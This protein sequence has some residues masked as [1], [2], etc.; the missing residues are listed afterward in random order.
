MDIASS[1]MAAALGFSIL[2]SPATAEDDNNSE[3]NT[4]PVPSNI[5]CVYSIFEDGTYTEEEISASPVLSWLYKGY[6][7][8]LPEPEVLSEDEIREWSFSECAEYVGLS[9]DDF[10]LFTQTVNAE[11]GNTMAD[12][13]Y[14]AA[15]IWNRM[16]CKKWYG[17]DVSVSR[18]IKSPNQ[19]A[20]YNPETDTV[21]G[22][23][24]DKN[25]Q[26]AI[27]LAYDG[28]ENFTIP[29]SLCYFNSVGYNRKSSEEYYYDGGNYFMTNN[30][31]GCDWCA[32]G[33]GE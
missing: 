7:E 2:F 29:H 32:A 11:S 5:T 21:C 12:K 20:V 18:V 9:E 27:V 13:T 31:C 14:V 4:T 26:V 6:L 3:N 22:S 16:R 17:Y 33:E 1:I 23:S 25:A 30:S 19:F 24:K 8:S 10:K 15:T 28:L